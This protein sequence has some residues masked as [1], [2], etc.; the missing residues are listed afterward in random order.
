VRAFSTENGKIELSGFGSLLANVAL[1]QSARGLAHSTT[2]AHMTSARSF[3]P[4]PGLA[5]LT[6]RTDDKVGRKL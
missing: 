6:G 2:L 3:E 5:L 4:F 1:G